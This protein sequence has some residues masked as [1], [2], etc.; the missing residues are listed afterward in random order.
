[1]T[2]VILFIP[3]NFQYKECPFLQTNEAYHTKST[4]NQLTGNV[5]T[6]QCSWHINGPTVIVSAAEA[7]NALSKIGKT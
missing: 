1:M 4:D 5:K 6:R 3:V 2:S 7:N